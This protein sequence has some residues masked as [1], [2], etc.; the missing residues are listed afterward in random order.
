MVSHTGYY[1]KNL[2][3]GHFLVESIGKSRLPAVMLYVGLL[4]LVP[5]RHSP[6]Y[7]SGQRFLDRPG[8]GVRRLRDLSG[9][10]GSPKSRAVADLPGIVFTRQSDR[11]KFGGYNRNCTD[12]I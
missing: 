10:G 11:P 1:T 12:E 7:L 9:V 5:N 4:A 6:D 3:F 2:S 8:C